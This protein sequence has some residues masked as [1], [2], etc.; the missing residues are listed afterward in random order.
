MRNR[1]EELD[2]RRI[3]EAEGFRT[4]IKLLRERLNE[5]NRQIIKVSKI[6]LKNC[7]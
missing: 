2:R 7:K 5:L 6:D 4:D 1:Y 3:L